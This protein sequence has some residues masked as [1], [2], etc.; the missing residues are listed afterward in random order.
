MRAAIT[1]LIVA[2][3]TA[4]AMAQG[5]PNTLAMSCAGAQ[6]LVARAGA[7]VI[8]TG[9]STYDRIVAHRGFCTPSETVEPVFAPTADARACLV[10]Q[11]C[12]E[13]IQE[14]FR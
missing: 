14:T 9:V 8:G 2:G 3:M 4:G 13:R 12:L 7:I 10:G 5:R 1:A 11:R 6:A